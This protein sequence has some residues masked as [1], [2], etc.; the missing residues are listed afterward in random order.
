MTMLN[1]ASISLVL[2]VL[3]SMLAGCGNSALLKGNEAFR[4]GDY[5]AARAHWEGPAENAVVGAQHNLGV[6]NAQ[7]GDLEAAATWWRQAVAQEFV[8]SMLALGKL[9]LARGEPKSAH[10]LFHR[11]ARWSNSEAIAALEAMNKPVPDA[12]LW[13]TR[14][15]SLDSRQA[16]IARELSRPDPNQHLNRMLDQQAAMAEND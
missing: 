12:D 10:A 13:R 1:K 15:R 11:A 14:M 16:R 4:S 2:A 8:P 9:E 7:L 5:Q 3:A 6:L